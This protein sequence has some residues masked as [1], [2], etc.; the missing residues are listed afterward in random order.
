MTKYI[1]IIE[2]GQTV[3]RFPEPQDGSATEQL[4]EIVAMEIL[5]GHNKVNKSTAIKNAIAFYHA[6]LIKGIA[7]EHNEALHT[8]S[9]QEDEHS[10]FGN[11]DQ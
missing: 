5:R 7:H 8:L 10:D 11:A 3:F 4:S 9:A 6:A 2:R 1:R